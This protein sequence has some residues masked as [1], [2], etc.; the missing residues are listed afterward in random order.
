MPKGTKVYN[1]V[2]DVKRKG[3]GVNPYAVCQKATGMSYATGEKIKS[4]LPKGVDLSP[5][6]DIGEH[7][8]MEMRAAFPRRIKD[9]GRDIVASRE[10][11]SKGK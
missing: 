2:Q 6:G 9:A 4:H 8:Q 5:K 11:P 10:L 1:C 3:E 7:R